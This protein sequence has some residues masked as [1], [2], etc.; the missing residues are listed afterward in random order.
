[1]SEQL[2]NGITDET[3]H[4]PTS[5]LNSGSV[6]TPITHNSDHQSPVI[7]ENNFDIPPINPDVLPTS[8]NGN[9]DEIIGGRTTQV[10]RGSNGTPTVNHDHQPPVSG[11]DNLDIPPINRDVLR[12]SENGNNDEINGGRTTQ[13][14]RGSNGTPITHNS[15]QQSSVI[16]ENNIDIQPINPDVLPTREIGN[17]IEIIGGLNMSNSRS[18]HHVV[19]G[20]S[21]QEDQSAGPQTTLEHSRE[22]SVDENQSSLTNLEVLNQGEGTGN[23]VDSSSTIQSPHSSFDSTNQNGNISVPPLTY[24][25]PSGLRNS[26]SLS[27]LSDESN[28]NIASEDHGSHTQVM[29]GDVGEIVHS[30]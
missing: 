30:D 7:G 29:S 25:V 22:P 9:N 10:N 19:A 17:N 11:V 15:D 23:D 1:M 20:S 27:Q 13:V 2:T 8:E 5:Q 18:T 3:V 24:E 21:N 4:V 14:N 28:N 6:G 12:T 16:G 26:D